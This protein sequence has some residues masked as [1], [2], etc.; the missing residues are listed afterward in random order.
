MIAVQCDKARYTT[1]ITIIPQSMYRT[2]IAV[3]VHLGRFVSRWMFKGLKIE[4]LLLYIFCST[5]LAGF[6]LKLLILT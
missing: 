1:S 6:S 3:E 4:I 2:Q 5:F